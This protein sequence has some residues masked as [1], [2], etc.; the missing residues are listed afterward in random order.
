MTRRFPFS[1]LAG[2]FAALAIVAS[3]AL[4]ASA[5]DF[6]KHV[7]FDVSPTFFGGATTDAQA[8]APV[9]TF[10][11]GYTQDHPTTNDWRVNYGLN[12]Q[13]NRRTSLYYNHANFD[14]ELGRILLPGVS[15]VSGDVTDRTDTIGLN[16][17]A[18]RF[19]STRVYFFD[20]ERTDVTGLCLNQ[21]VC[22]GGVRNPA[23]IDEHGY[24]AGGTWS[25]GPRSLIGP[26]FS[27]GADAKYV[28]RSL[29]G[30]PGAALD[31]LGSYTGS[32][33]EFPYSFTVK[34]PTHHDPSLIWVA[35]YERAT[36]L[37]RAESS[38]E[39]Y[40]VTQFG[41][42]KVLS[43][44][45]TVSAFDLNFKGC[46]CAD[47]VAPPDNVRFAGIVLSLSYKFGLAH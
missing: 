35:G 12:V 10:P 9:G 1:R 42:V 14:F 22:G 34:V 43:P 5:D 27:I 17:A 4:P 31:G 28:P 44:R 30:P 13:L 6:L 37:F 47:T 11:L 46:R 8:P 38:I 45:F 36:A 15:L 21:T 41:V 24:A 2:T 33:F 19:L 29:P 40:N 25:F 39:Q 3:A 32:Q 23:A 18:T 7:T 16:Y 20:H 26:I